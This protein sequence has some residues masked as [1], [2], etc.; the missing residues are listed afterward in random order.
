MDN[1]KISAEEDGDHHRRDYLKVPLLGPFWH[2]MDLLLKFGYNVFFIHVVSS[3]H[4]IGCK[5][6]YCRII[7][8]E[9]AVYV[10][11]I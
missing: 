9:N 10:D 8:Y 2:N 1:I 6:R 5:Q 4:G 7:V 11:T 3:E